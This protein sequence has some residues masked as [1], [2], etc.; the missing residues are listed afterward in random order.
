MQARIRN[1]STG[2]FEP[3]CTQRHHAIYFSSQ[4]NNSIIRS[5]SMTRRLVENTL[6]TL[7]HFRLY[8]LIRFLTDY[9]QIF[10]EEN[11]CIAKQ[12]FEMLLEDRHKFNSNVLIFM[13]ITYYYGLASDSQNIVII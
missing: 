7:A 3:K 5:T 6:H 11:L 4:K 1:L 9:F 12:N 2:E 8:R 13:F 10:Y